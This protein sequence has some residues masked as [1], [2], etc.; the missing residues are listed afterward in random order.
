V[1]V[2]YQYH[3]RPRRGRDRMVVGFTTTN[4]PM[5]LVIITTN[6][7]SSNLAQG[8]VYSIQHYMIKFVCAFR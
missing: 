7:V 4:V 6:V 3:P 5:Q 1:I 2:I 8:S